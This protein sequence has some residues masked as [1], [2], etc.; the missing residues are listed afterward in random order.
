MDEKNVAISTM[1]CHSAIKKNKVM[2]ST[3][4]WIELEI[5]MLS[6]IR[7]TRKR[8]VSHI[9]TYVDFLRH[10]SRRRTIRE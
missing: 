8:E 10:E 2:L 6:E 1:Q 5:I 7:Q 4:K 9:F 3:G